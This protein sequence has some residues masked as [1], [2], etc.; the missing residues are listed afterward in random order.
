MLTTIDYEKAYLQTCAEELKTYLLS[1]ELFW[2]TGLRA[3][4]AMPPYPE[5]TLGNMI[6]SQAL[7][8]AMAINEADSPDIAGIDYIVS[9][10]DTVH[11]RWRVAWEK[12]AQ[13]E[14]AYR[15][16]QWNTYLNDLRVNYKSSASNYSVQVRQ[17]VL[18]ELVGRE[19]GDYKGDQ[20]NISSLDNLLRGYF[21]VGEFLWQK[22]L[23]EGF[24]QEPFWYLWGKLREG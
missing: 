6:L 11:K 19:T 2:P 7:V 18:L 3:S 15:L 17:R 16:R 23:A 5:M 14:F 22:G 10:I 4:S 24:P 20:L 1:K 8:N 12:K 21:Q 13:R 9:Q